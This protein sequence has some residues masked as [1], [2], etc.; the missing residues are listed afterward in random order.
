MNMS[1]KATAMTIDPAPGADARRDTLTPWRNPMKLAFALLLMS[2][3]LGA[4]SA[5]FA[6]GQGLSLFPDA[7]LA[8]R[9]APDAALTL[10]D[11]EGEENDDEGEGGWFWS[12]SGDDDEEDDDD[13]RAAGGIGNAAKAGSAPPPQNGLFTNGTAPVVKS[14]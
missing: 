6:A 11:D 14:N 2:T 4:G 5:T 8:S 13:D 12:L 9:P 3:T 10:I 1:T 7:S